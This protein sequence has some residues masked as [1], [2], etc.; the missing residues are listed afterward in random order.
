[1]EV[2]LIMLALLLRIIVFFLILKLLNMQETSVVLYF[3]FIAIKKV[4][5]LESTAVY[6]KN[7]CSREG[8][9]DQ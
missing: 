8:K 3:L 7:E 4:C 1:M 6:E 5:Q 9:K 2:K